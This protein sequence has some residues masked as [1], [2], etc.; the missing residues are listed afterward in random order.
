MSDFKLFWEEAVKVLY[1]EYENQNRA[2]EFNLWI[3]AIDYVDSHDSVVF[4]SVPSTFF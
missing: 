4:V 2:D 3:N 1:S